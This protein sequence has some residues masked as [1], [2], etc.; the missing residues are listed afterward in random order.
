YAIVIA[1]LVAPTVSAPLAATV[2][3]YPTLSRSLGKIIGGGLPV[4]AYGGPRALMGRISPLGGVYQ[5]GTLSGNP[6]AVAADSPRACPPRSEDHTSEL[7]SH[8]NLVCR[9]LPAH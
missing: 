7:Q 3:P 1:A 8:L 5:A 6:L 4:G 2:F 9:L